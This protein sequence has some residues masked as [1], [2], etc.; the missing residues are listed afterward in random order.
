MLK[1]FLMITLVLVFAHPQGI[2]WGQ[3]VRISAWYWLNAAPKV[4]WEGD[5]LTMKK[6]GFTD[7]VLCWGIDLAAVGFRTED[8]KAAIEEAYRA[9]LKSYLVVWQPTANSLPRLP[10]FEQVD[11]AGNV[12]FSFDVFNPEWRQT[13]WKK[14]LQTVAVAYRGEPGM[15]GYV[16]DDSFTLGPVATERGPAGSG[17]VAYGK[18]EQDHFGGDLP[19]K[20]TDPRWNEWVTARQNWWEDWAKDTVGFIRQV[21]KN[22]AHQIYLEDPADDVLHPDRIKT[23]GLDLNRVAKH[24]DA[25]GAYSD[26][27]YRGSPED[28]AKVV[29]GTQDILAKVTQEV[30]KEKN[31]IYTFWVANPAEELAPG[32][33]KFPTVKQ[34]RLIADA[35]L[36]AGIRHLDMYGYR[37]GDYRVEAGTME[38]FSPGG[39]TTYPLTEQ[40]PQKFLWDRPEIQ[41]ELGNY[42]RGLNTSPK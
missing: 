12:L 27:A 26:F 33:A 39:G 31:T 30:G 36:Q 35:A 21:D 2:A 42:L 28:N 32:L 17:M 11:S 19:R 40:F 34:I 37:I 3:K 5:F 4:A 41:E 13:S 23:I 38:K 1:R 25:F 18:Y 15:A 14:Y 10:G 22:P 16:F 6:M 24:F 7:V 8:T 20:V 9:G 29:K